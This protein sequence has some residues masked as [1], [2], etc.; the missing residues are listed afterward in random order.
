MFCEDVAGCDKSLLQFWQF[1]EFW[2]RELFLYVLCLHC[3]DEIVDLF[4]FLAAD[5][6]DSEHSSQEF[7]GSQGMEG[8]SVA[9]S[10]QEGFEGL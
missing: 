3:S 6:Q 5:S 1:A 10:Q 4:P 7:K 2:N 9:N 8:I